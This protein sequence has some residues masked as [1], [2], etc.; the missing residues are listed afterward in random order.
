MKNL[1]S[2]KVLFSKVMIFAI[3]ALI[4]VSVSYVQV[5]YATDTSTGT[6]TVGLTPGSGYVPVSGYTSYTGVDL[7]SAG[8]SEIYGVTPEGA[9]VTLL[10]DA[11]GDKDLHFDDT[12]SAG[13]YLLYVHQTSVGTPW[14]KVTIIHPS[15]VRDKAFFDSLYTVDGTMTVGLS[16][17]SGYAPAE[18]YITY[19]GVDL[20]SGAASE[21]YGVSPE[22]AVVKLD[23]D[24]NGDKDLHFADTHPAGTYY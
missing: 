3:F 11:N 16:E 10:P 7:S 8:A 19:T 14:V 17:G 6:M 1:M 18:G 20:S 12:H 22:G 21:I 13:T 2:G 24:T 9:V 5:G 23:P 4:L 15:T